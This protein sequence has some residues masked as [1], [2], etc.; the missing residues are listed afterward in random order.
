MR[1][2]HPIVILGEKILWE[3]GPVKLVRRYIQGWHPQLG[4]LHFGLRGRETV[5]ESTVIRCSQIVNI[6]EGA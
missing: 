5:M 4:T 2:V 3:R 1:E 6:S